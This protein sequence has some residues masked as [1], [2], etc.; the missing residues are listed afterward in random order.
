MDWGFG[1][2][3]PLTP[4]FGLLWEAS[5]HGSPEMAR[6]DKKTDRHGTVTFILLGAM[7]FQNRCR[8]RSAPTRGK[9]VTEM[10]DAAV[11]AN[12]LCRI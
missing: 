9:N 12:G 4:P 1:D 2:Q 6:H 3:H 7:L 5:F 11:C 8:D 10:F